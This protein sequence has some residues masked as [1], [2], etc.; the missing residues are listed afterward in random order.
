MPGADPTIAWLLAG[1]PAIRRT[2]FALERPGAPCRWN[3][4]RALRVRLWWGSKRN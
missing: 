1:D 3:T 4:P 2:F